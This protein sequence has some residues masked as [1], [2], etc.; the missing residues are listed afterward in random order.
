MTTYTLPTEDLLVD[1]HRI[2][3][4]HGLEVG[5]RDLGVVGRS[6]YRW[7]LYVQRP[8]DPGP[9]LSIAVREAGELVGAVR[10]AWSTFIR[11]GIV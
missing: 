5:I 7:F 11:W 1:L 2:A 3:G 4:R 10:E 8:G 6:P 9:H